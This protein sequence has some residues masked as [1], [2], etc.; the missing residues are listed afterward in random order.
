LSNTDGVS[1]K[2]LNVSFLNSIIY[3]HGGSAADELLVN[4][5]GSD[6][7]EFINCIYK[8]KDADPAGVLFTGCLKNVDPL[9]D[10]INTSLQQYNFRLK[11]ISPAIDWGKSN[12]L[13][14]DLDG[15]PRPVGNKPDTG[16][17][18]KQ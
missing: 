16:C 6:K 14:V 13:V 12:S 5:S 1:A 10:S 17:Y 3:G 11:D 15:N 4:K 2:P 7:V 18:E 9:F 8:V